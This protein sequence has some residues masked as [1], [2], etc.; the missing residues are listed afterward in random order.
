M[1]E[2]TAA[3]GGNSLN[4]RALLKNQNVDI[5]QALFII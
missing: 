4:R 2:E 1:G 3:N 5:I